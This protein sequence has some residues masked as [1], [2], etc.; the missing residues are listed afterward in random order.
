MDKYKTV[1]LLIQEPE[2][3]IIIKYEMEWTELFQFYYHLML[4]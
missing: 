4:N 3:H 1:K 2:F